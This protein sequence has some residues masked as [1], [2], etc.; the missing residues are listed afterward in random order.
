VTSEREPTVHPSGVG[1]G[2]QCS[3]LSLA[4]S[5]PGSGTARGADEEDRGREPVPL[6]RG[7]DNVEVVGVPVIEREH[8]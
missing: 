5:I 2:Q 1:Q 3:S 6:D 8:D 7:Q 4:C